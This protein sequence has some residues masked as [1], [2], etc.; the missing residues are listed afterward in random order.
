MIEIEFETAQPV[1]LNNR[2]H[3]LDEEFK[4]NKSSNSPAF[5]HVE[6]EVNGTTVIIRY[7]FP[8]SEMNKAS[9]KALENA[10]NNH[11]CQ[12][13]IVAVRDV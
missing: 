1:V 6:R 4:N 13:R 10:F 5:S 7:D 3:D 2:F 8:A 12:G 11:V 9:K